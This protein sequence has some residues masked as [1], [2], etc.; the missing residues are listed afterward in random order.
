MILEAGA[1]QGA[2]DVDVWN[3]E[4]YWNCLGKSMILRA[5][6]LRGPRLWSWYVK[7][8]WNTIGKAMI[9]EAHSPTG[10]GRGRGRVQAVKLIRWKVLKFNRKSIDFWSPQPHRGGARGSAASKADTIE[11]YWISIGKAYISRKHIA[12]PIGNQWFS[13]TL[14]HWGGWVG[15]APAADHIYIYI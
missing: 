8:Y 9:F 5:G 2:Q 13:K 12:K 11:K 15:G 6:P 14:T 7:K 3:I 1:P 4:K 10:G